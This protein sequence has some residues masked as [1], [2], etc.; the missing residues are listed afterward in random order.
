MNYDLHLIGGD[1]NFD[2]SSNNSGHSLFKDIINDYN[3]VC[4]DDKARN[5][6]IG[7]TYFHESLNQHSWLDHFVVSKCLYDLIV[8]CDIID[9][10]ENLS[11]HCP[12]QCVLNLNIKHAYVTDSNSENAKRRYKLRWDKADILSYYIQSGS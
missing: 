1:Y 12:L 2:F 3:L 9:T 8:Q 10:G 4:C 11:D 6:S 5:K 7:Y